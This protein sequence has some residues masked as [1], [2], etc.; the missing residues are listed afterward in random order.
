MCIRDRDYGGDPTGRTDSTTAMLA[1]VAAVLQHDVGRMAD[2]ITNLGGATLDLRGGEYLISSPV[3]IPKLTGNVRVR[4]GSLK[5]SSSFPASRFLIEVGEEG[6]NAKVPQGV[7]NE[8][9]GFD[10]LLLDASH[11]AAG[12][13][14][15]ANTMGTT[16]GPSAFFTGFVQA[17]VRVLQGHETLVYD[18]WFAEEYWSEHHPNSESVGIDL[19]G[20]DNYISNTIVFDYTKLG[21]RVNGAASLLEGVHT[22]NGG[23]VGILINGSYAIQ[24]RL[25]SCYLDYNTLT[26]VDP[27]QTT[28][29]NTFFLDTQAVL[30]QHNKPTI[31]SVVFRDNVYSF[32]KAAI[33]QSIVVEGQFATCSNVIVTDEVSARACTT[34]DHWQCGIKQTRAQQSVRVSNATQVTLDFGAQLLF[35]HID[36][37][38]YS[39]SVARGC[40]IEDQGHV[41][42]EPEGTQVTVTFKSPTSG[43]V[44]MDV[45][46]CG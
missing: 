21:V 34:S 4:G 42:Y 33:N 46:Q 44:H 16:V 32:G 14:Q 40:N 19:N 38:Q 25:L 6:C 23:G 13:I 35:A 27:T 18:S 39:V 20:Q 31:Q 24:D 12:G 26:I 45:S 29:E 8:F 3:I 11:T 10:N 15:V 2:N 28:V 7:C 43:T 22:W 1:A 30:L 41:A 5:A 17:G 37:L 9:V 36:H